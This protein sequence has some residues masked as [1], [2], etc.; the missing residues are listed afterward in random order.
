MARAS[1]PGRAFRRNLQ[2]AIV[3]IRPSDF[4]D[5][6][7]ACRIAIASPLSSELKQQCSLHAARAPSS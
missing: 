5:F 3:Q 2:F 4:S 6:E 7:A 1:Q